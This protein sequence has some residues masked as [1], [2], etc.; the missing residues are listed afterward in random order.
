MKAD[1]RSTVIIEPYE[2][3]YGANSV[4]GAWWVID[5]TTR[6]HVHI[7]RDRDEAIAWVQRI[8]APSQSGPAEGI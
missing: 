5:R 1:D 3:R 6:I 2:I 8:T 4:V 7:F